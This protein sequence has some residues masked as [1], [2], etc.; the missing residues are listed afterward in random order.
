[1]SFSIDNTSF[2]K[3]CANIPKNSSRIYAFPSGPPSL[4]VIMRRWSEELVVSRTRA[5][6][7]FFAV[8][9]EKANDNTS[10]HSLLHRKRGKEHRAMRSTKGEQEKKN[11][12]FV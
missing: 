4:T 12:C 11:H 10:Q 6:H 7:S 3:Q 8:R 9:D 1:M 2:F 5:Q